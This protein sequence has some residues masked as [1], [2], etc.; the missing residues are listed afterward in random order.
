[1]TGLAWASREGLGQVEEIG[2]AMG[3]DTKSAARGS[4][5]STE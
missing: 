4:P 5:L 3:Q 1:M 2:Q